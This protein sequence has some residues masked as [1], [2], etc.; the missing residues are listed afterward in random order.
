[1]LRAEIF[2]CTVVPL[3]CDILGYISWKHCKNRPF[4]TFF[5]YFRGLLGSHDVFGAWPPARGTVKPVI[6]AALNFDD[7]VC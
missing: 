5:I 4:F 7:S 3:I 6:L 1:M 2:L